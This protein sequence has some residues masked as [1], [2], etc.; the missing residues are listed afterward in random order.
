MTSS[1]PVEGIRPQRC[2]GFCMVGFVEGNNAGIYL[3]GWLPGSENKDFL[4]AAFWIP[5]ADLILCSGVS[6]TVG[7]LYP[8]TAF[9]S[10]SGVVR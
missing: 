9:G 10:L 7:V 2:S 4:W 3:V 5:E 6:D 1:C 8:G